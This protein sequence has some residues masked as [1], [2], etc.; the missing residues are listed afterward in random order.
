METTSE[1]K[2]SR[3]LATQKRIAKGCSILVLVSVMIVKVLAHRVGYDRKGNPTISAVVTKEKREG[4][5]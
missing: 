4:L 5:V 1:G 3:Y 2:V